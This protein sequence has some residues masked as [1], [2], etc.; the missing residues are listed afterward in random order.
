MSPETL[1]ALN[2]SIK[3]WESIVHGIGTDEGA[4]NCPLCTMYL[5]NG[6]NGAF[7]FS[8]E[9]CLG[10]PVAEEVDSRGCVGTPYTDWTQ[11]LRYHQY[12]GYPVKYKVFDKESLRL[13]KEELRFLRSLLPNNN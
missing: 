2:G 6:G 13:A 1:K 3:K 11:Y 12:S 8:E 5:S 9:E 10:C 7:E 4:K